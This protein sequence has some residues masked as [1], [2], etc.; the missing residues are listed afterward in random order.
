MA[1]MTPQKQSAKEPEA[2]K[3]AGKRARSKK[4]DDDRNDPPGPGN[5]I[6]TLFPFLQPRS[7]GGLSF[8]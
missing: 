3:R 8:A 2:S 4:D 1:D 5:A 7:F 6:V